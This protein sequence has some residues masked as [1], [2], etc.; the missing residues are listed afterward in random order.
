MSPAYLGTY[1]RTVVPT[2]G[3]SGDLPPAPPDSNPRSYDLGRVLGAWL[4]FASP[5]SLESHWS[6]AEKVLGGGEA[7]G[8]VESNAL[9]SPLLTTAEMRDLHSFL[10]LPGLWTFPQHLLPL[11]L[12]T[13]LGS[14]APHRKHLTVTMAIWEGEGPQAGAQSSGG[15]QPQPRLEDEIDFLAQ[16]LARK[17]SGY[18]T[19]PLPE[20]R[21]RLLEPATLGFSARGQGLELGL[22]S[23]PGAPTPPPHTSLG[24]PVSSEPVHMSPLEPRGGHGDGLALVL[25]LAFCVA[26]AAALSVASFC[27]C[28]LQREIRLTQKADYA[29]AKDPGSAAAPRTSVGAPSALRLLPRSG[30]HLTLAPAFPQPGDQR[31]AHSAEMYHYQHQRQQMLCLERLGHWH[32]KVWENQNP[33]LPIPPRHKE[34]PKE[35]DTASSDEENEDGDFTV[36]E[37][38]GLA[39][40]GGAISWGSL[41]ASI[42]LLTR[43]TARHPCPQTGEME[44]RNPLFDHAVLS[45]PLPAPG[46]QTPTCSLTM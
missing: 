38:P 45:A 22:P 35:L 8:A 7:E 32:L 37:C 39:P 3:P 15:G 4:P 42:P 6:S 27:W 13:L 25:I 31:L 29:I 33:A 12:P 19:P 24:S 30:R 2:V 16:E 14:T 17:E 28:R 11:A 18:S 46:G 5:H 43:C 20:A 21:Q 10:P 23:T 1:A 44:V 36:Y 26:G 9:P 40:G 41:P 34:P